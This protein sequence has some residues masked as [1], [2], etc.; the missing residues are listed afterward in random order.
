ME[1]KPIV[2]LPDLGSARQVEE[3]SAATQGEAA[4]DPTWVACPSFW[5]LR[6]ILE[7]EVEVEDGGEVEPERHC[8]DEEG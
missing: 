3:L 4:L 8:L 1:G 7:L 6:L 2:I 5:V